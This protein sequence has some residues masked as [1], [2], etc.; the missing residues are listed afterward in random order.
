MG[1]NNY[2]RQCSKNC[3]H[4][5]NDVDWV[6]LVL[7]GCYNECADQRLL[8]MYNNTPQ[9]HTWLRLREPCVNIS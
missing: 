8:L 9:I 3:D 2:I 5:S 6:R 1:S 4:V 7:K